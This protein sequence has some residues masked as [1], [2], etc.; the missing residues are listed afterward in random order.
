MHRKKRNLYTL[1]RAYFIKFNLNKNNE[2]LPKDINYTI[3][4]KYIAF[5]NNRLKKQAQYISSTKENIRRQREF[6]LVKHFI[7]KAIVDVLSSTPQCEKTNIRLSLHPVPKSNIFKLSVSLQ[8]V[9]PLLG[10]FMMVGPS[11]AH[12]IGLQKE[13]HHRVI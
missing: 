12:R 5:F 3:Q 8:W 10:T 7:D 1:E 6:L 4:S 2:T 11:V 9:Y 13:F